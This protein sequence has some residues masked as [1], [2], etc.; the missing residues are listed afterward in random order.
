M[1]K[2]KNIG[3][4]VIV[5]IATAILM[6]PFTTGILLMVLWKLGIIG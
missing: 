2:L 1:T 5:L 4:V 3:T 6:Y